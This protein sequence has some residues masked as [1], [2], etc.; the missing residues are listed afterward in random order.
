M[1]S[2]SQLRELNSVPTTTDYAVAKSRRAR[3]AACS[4]ARS[5]KPAAGA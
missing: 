4:E 3:A 5:C 2:S 1:L